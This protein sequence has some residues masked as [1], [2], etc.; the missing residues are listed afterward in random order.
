VVVKVEFVI[1]ANAETI[2]RWLGRNIMSE[3]TMPSSY[4]ESEKRG[5]KYV[6]I[7]RAVDATPEAKPRK[8]VTDLNMTLYLCHRGNL[9]RFCIVPRNHLRLWKK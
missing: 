6:C 1:E 2:G 9:S 8:R 4:I 7:M 3:L 5:S